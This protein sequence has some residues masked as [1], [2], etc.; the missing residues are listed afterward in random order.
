MVVE[1][2]GGRGDV[3]LREITRCGRDSFS[4]N[5]LNLILTFWNIHSL[6]ILWEKRF[7]SLSL[8]LS[9]AKHDG[10]GA[11]VTLLPEIINLFS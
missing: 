3:I 9:L 10:P 2:E 6:V 8:S 1:R 5:K 4:L 11:R 7:L